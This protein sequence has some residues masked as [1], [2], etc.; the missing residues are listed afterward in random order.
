MRS[1]ST[2][3]SL[4]L[5][6]LLLAL[7]GAASAAMPSGQEQLS[8]GTTGTADARMLYQIPTGS[9]PVTGARYL[10]FAPGNLYPPYAADPFR[11]GFGF[12][13]V[14]VAKSSIPDTSKSRVNLRAGGVL[15][16]VRSQEDERPDTGWQLSI[17]GGFN[18]QNDVRNSLDNI[19]W[20]G[21]YG[22]LYM[23]APQPSLAFKF[24]VLHVSSHVGDEYAERTGRRRIGYTRQE[25][26]AG[27]SWFMAERWRL[28]AETGRAFFMSTR[29]LQE[30]WR[31]QSG[32]EYES[33]PV[34]WRHRLAWYAALDVQAMQERDWRADVSFQSGVVARSAGRT[35]RLGAAW[36]N[37]RPM[38]GEFFQ[39]TERYL[40]VGLWIDI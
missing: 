28:Y 29:Q 33:P 31:W 39:Y 2:P 7:A 20:D 21:R 25:L 3:A 24:G 40:S 13:P 4:I 37:G 36:Y 16:I 9:N 18:D 8:T 19:G 22:L 12:E 38:I 17:L 11:V 15:T 23:T 6:L 5:G 35:W 32:L 14:H 26:A 1:L 10:Y 30:P 34:M 27:V